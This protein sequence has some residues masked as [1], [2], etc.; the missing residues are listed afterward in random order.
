MVGVALG[1]EEKMPSFQVSAIRRLQEKSASVEYE[2]QVKH[3][4]VIGPMARGRHW[5]TKNGN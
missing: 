1:V 2:E 4:I 5:R 3:Q